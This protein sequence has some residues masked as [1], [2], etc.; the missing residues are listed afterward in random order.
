MYTS[1]FG[2]SRIYLAFNKYTG[3]VWGHF[4]AKGKG[5]IVGYIARI[6]QQ[7]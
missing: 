2:H 4:E 6:L 7:I 1:A 5:D 3:K